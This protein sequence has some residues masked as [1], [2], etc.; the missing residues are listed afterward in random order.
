MSKRDI[1][2]LI[3]GKDEDI[4]PKTKTGC[5]KLLDDCGSGVTYCYRAAISCPE[6]Q[7]KAQAIAAMRGEGDLP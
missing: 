1:I 7:A 6:C 2:H 5:G 3:I 4:G